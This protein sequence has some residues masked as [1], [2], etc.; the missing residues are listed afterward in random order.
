MAWRTHLRWGLTLLAWP[1]CWGL[2]LV[3]WPVIA[4]AQQ[5]IQIRV[6]D[7][8]DAIVPGAAV[9]LYNH[10][11]K[12]Q[13]FEL[14]QSDGVAQFD[15]PS[16][17]RRFSYVASKE[18]YKGYAE[19]PKRIS[20][21]DT[22]HLKDGKWNT[23]PVCSERPVA[24]AFFIDNRAATTESDRVTLWFRTSASYDQ[25]V[26]FCA[27]D[28]P[29][30]C[31]PDNGVW[32][33]LGRA[34]DDFEP[35]FTSEHA[36]KRIG[37]QTV[38]LSVRWAA[39]EPGQS[40]AA[41][42]ERIPRPINVRTLT[43]NDGAAFTTTPEVT[44]EWI[45]EPLAADAGVEFCAVVPGQTCEDND[46]KADTPSGHA[47]GIGPRFRQQHPLSPSQLAGFLP[48]QRSVELRARYADY[49]KIISTPITDEILLLEPPGDTPPPGTE[50]YDIPAG[51]VFELASSRGWG[52]SFND[53]TLCL[54]DPPPPNPNT[55]GFSIGTS[56][57]CSFDLFTN[58]TLAPGWTFQEFQVDDSN[59]FPDPAKDCQ[60]AEALSPTPGGRS[61]RTLVVVFKR[62][63][64]RCLVCLDPPTYCLRTF[65]RV[66]LEGP[67]NADWRTAFPMSSP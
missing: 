51:Q 55:Q 3:A 59:S 44:L 32:V 67:A 7:D 13:D 19:G 24:T 62:P 45:T 39:G 60:F 35:V 52:F 21:V 42:I 46:W 18:G 4:A 50:P 54:L 31:D 30:E 65:E 33:S 10:N 38:H 57:A 66:R 40:A 61:L 64:P 47:P 12:T 9:C 6:V 14:T 8:T 5:E 63:W 23:G 43:I 20:S 17:N 49:P 29:D 56:S 53:P 41:S 2:T 25:D 34:N 26:E 11:D 28:D 37:N 48:V 58:G 36:L 27:T 16:G 1:I 15:I 22:A